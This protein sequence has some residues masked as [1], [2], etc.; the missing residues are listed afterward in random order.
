MG[1]DMCKIINETHSAKFESRVYSYLTGLYTKIRSSLVILSKQ[2]TCIIEDCCVY[3]SLVI[4]YYMKDTSVE[5][6]EDIRVLLDC[7][8]IYYNCSILD[9]IH[10]T[11]RSIIEFI[12]SDRIDRLHSQF[13]RATA[14]LRRTWSV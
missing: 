1:L 2:A 13:I 5:L 8:K 12:N 10:T 4:S 14:D 11:V 3:K 9:N 7:I 6:L